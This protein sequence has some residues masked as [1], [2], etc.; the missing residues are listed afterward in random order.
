MSTL[1]SCWHHSTQLFHVFHVFLKCCQRT[2]WS[3]NAES[4]FSS[5][6]MSVDS[7]TT[8]CAFPPCSAVSFILKTEL[9]S[10]TIFF[11]GSHL[12]YLSYPLKSCPIFPSLSLLCLWKSFFM[13]IL[14]SGKGNFWVLASVGHMGRGKLIKCL[15]SLLF[16]IVLIKGRRVQRNFSLILFERWLW[17]NQWERRVHGCFCCRIIRLT[18]PPHIATVKGTVPFC[19]ISFPYFIWQ[20]IPYQWTPIFS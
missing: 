1:Y 2:V 19:Y 13:F 16:P 3:L 7:C 5:A 11:F 6:Y 9:D 20:T 12:N 8:Y 15:M 10:K 18:K 14:T 4:L 17:D